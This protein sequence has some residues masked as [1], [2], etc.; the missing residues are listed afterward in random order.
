MRAEPHSEPLREF[1]ESSDRDLYRFCAMMSA[2]GEDL[3]ALIVQIFR[4]F[5]RNVYRRRRTFPSTAELQIELFR[6]ALRSLADPG[7]GGARTFSAGRD[8]RQSQALER[9]LLAGGR[10]QK[11]DPGLSKEQ[12]ALLGDRLRLLDFDLRAPVLLHDLLGVEA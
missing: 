2:A 3:E 10:S 12:L 11:G 4:T 9:N 1:V 8:T 7:G 5:A 6:T